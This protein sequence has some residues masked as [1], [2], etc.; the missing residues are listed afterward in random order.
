MDLKGAKK[1]AQTRKWRDAKKKADKTAKEAKTF[2]KKALKEKGGFECASFE[3]KTGHE[4]TGIVDVVGLR[5]DKGNRDMLEMVLVQVKGGS[6]RI[7]PE[8]LARLQEASKNVR[9]I[10]TVA[11][12]RDRHVVF[13]PDPFQSQ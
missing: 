10:Y 11:E 1:A 7:K 8:H 6:A 5:R 3:S 12:K 9:V 13:T 4:S 2:A